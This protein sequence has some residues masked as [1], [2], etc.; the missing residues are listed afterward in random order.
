MDASFEAV[1]D[2]IKGHMR[3]LNDLAGISGFEQEVLEYL[4]RFRCV[5][6]R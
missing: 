6:V 4:R 1:R 2:R 5:S 3:A